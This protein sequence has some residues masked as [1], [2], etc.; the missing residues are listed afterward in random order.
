V[1]AKS[2]VENAGIEA[3]VPLWEFAFAV[4]LALAAPGPV[5][6]SASDPAISRAGTI[7]EIRSFMTTSL[8][9]KNRGF[10]R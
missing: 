1:R 4:F 7:R 10:G 2:S 8:A 3:G 9:S 5:A 6:T